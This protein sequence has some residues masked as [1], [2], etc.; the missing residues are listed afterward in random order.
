VQRKWKTIDALKSNG[1]YLKKLW[2]TE[3]FL[4]VIL[5]PISKYKGKT[6]ATCSG[7][8]KVGDWSSLG[9]ACQVLG[10]GNRKLDISLYWKEAFSYRLLRC[11]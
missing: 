9:I 2:E 1:K 11:S 6:P 8:K 7:P 5:F 4:M 3:N 10:H